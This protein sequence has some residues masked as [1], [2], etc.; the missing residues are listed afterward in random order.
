MNL[1][2]FL[3]GTFERARRER[4]A[5]HSGEP[6]HAGAPDIWRTLGATNVS[7]LHAVRGDGADPVAFPAIAALVAVTEE[8]RRALSGRHAVDIARCPFLVG[9]ESRS[10]NLPATP[11]KVELRLGIAPQVNDI[12]LVEPAWTDLL[13]ISRE[14]FLID[15]VGDQ[16]FVVDRGSVC[17]TIVSGKRIG[18]GR[19]GG[20]TE[21]RHGD[22][23]VVGTS[24]S[25][26]VFRFEVMLVRPDR[27]LT[28]AV[29]D[30]HETP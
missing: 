27:V 25:D 12:Y 21:L 11:P 20:R 9:R 5:L 15:R 1:R 17:G 23:I 22:V 16:F 7:E 10:P 28:D 4:S 26:Y 8:A 18:G 14:H 13:H 29:I 30:D 2:A 24:S 19:R 6:P 3:V